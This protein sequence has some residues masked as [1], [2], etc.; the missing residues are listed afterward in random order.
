MKTTVVSCKTLLNEVSRAVDKFQ[1]PYEVRYVE[2]GLHNTPKKLTR[3][4]QEILDSIDEDCDTVLL[5]MGFC[6]N[7]VVGLN[8][9]N[10]QMIIPKMDDCIS[11][12]MGSVE[13][14]MQYKGTYFMTEGWIRGERNIW[15]EYE[16]CVEKFGEK[17]GM[18]IFDT[19][20]H[21]YNTVGLLDTGCFSLPAAEQE[22]RRIADHLHLQYARLDGTLEILEKLFK[23]RWDEAQFLRIPPHTTIQQQDCI[24]NP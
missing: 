9:G 24:L 20:F 23:G 17:V 5:A 19:M 3:R 4:L 18:E 8:T 22:T 15:R 6:G 11:L 7:S 21:N 10:F 13:R 1:C 14:R 12:L 16:Y 2:E